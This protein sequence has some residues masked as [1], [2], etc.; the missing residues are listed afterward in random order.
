M[1]IK[2]FLPAK[3]HGIQWEREN[4]LIL[5]FLCYLCPPYRD[6][7]MRSLW[8]TNKTKGL[9]FLICI[10]CL[11]RGLSLGI[12]FPVRSEMCP[13]M[14]QF[15][16]LPGSNSRVWGIQIH[17]SLPDATYLHLEGFSWSRWPNIPYQAIGLTWVQTGSTYTTDWYFYQ[18]G[19]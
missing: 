15:L 17:P 2:L 11:Q 14:G 12:N 13:M 6:F 7:A 9:Y 18:S 1:R 19:Y 16:G 8:N 4:C 5:G 10:P 3:P